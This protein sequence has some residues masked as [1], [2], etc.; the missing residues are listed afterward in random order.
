MTRQPKST[1]HRCPAAKTTEFR[2]LSRR[3]LTLAEVT[4]SALLVGLVITASLRSIGA[5]FRT[6]RTASE[7]TQSHALVEQLLNEIL[8]QS[9]EDPDETPV[10]GHEAGESQ[11]PTSRTDFDDLDDYDDWTASPP[12]SPTGAP[13][14]GFSGW[15]REARIEKLNASSYTS[16][17]DSAQDQ[18]LRMITITVTDP[19]GVSV[20]GVAYRSTDGGSQQA[21]G[22]DVTIV[23]WVGCDLQIGAGGRTLS[24]GTH[25]TNH[26]E[27]Q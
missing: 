7:Q 4:I 14:A 23:T 10:F 1:R 26:A 8:P 19:H 12:Q 21:A 27:D 17:P 11:S 22:V 20:T 25:L 15:S 2:R 9:Y 13:L 6:W 3:G 16:I 18:G 5:V 24:S